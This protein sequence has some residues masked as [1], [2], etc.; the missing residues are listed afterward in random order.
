MPA[1]SASPPTDL[2]APFTRPPASSATPSAAFIPP[3]INLPP[4]SAI[5]PIALFAPSNNLPA[6]SNRSPTIFLALSATLPMNSPAASAIFFPNLAMPSKMSPILPLRVANRPSMPSSKPAP[7]PLGSSSGTLVASGCI[8]SLAAAGRLSV[9]ISS[10][11]AG[12]GASPLIAFDI[13]SARRVITFWLMSVIRTPA[14]ADIWS[15]VFSTGFASGPVALDPP[16]GKPATRFCS[17]SFALIWS[18]LFCLISLKRRTIPV[19]SSLS[20]TPWKYLPT[21]ATPAA[22]A[23][24]NLPGRLL[25]FSCSSL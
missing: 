5:P 24:I 4:S 16:L 25:Y 12:G 2:T 3:L 17:Y 11:V 23:D 21:P 15:P 14:W 22:A 6:P 20:P 18:V 13:A 9:A 10:G 19:G 1:P 8:L 7:V